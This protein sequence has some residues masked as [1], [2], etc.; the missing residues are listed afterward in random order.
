MDRHLDC[1]N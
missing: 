1:S